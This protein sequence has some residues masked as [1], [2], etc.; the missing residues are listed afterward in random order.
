MVILSGFDFHE[1]S[2]CESQST[3]CDI[4]N[5]AESHIILRLLLHGCQGT[6]RTLLAVI[7]F[8][9]VAMEVLCLMEHWEQHR[10][11]P[12]CKNWSVIR[13][14]FSSQA[15]FTVCVESGGVAKISR[16]GSYEHPKAQDN[17]RSRI[18]WWSKTRGRAYLD[19]VFW[20]T[21][22]GVKLA[23]EERL[24]ALGQ[25]DIKLSPAALSL[26]S[27]FRNILGDRK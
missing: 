3:Q 14:H 16:F 13:D 8:L 24:Q 2:S 12:Q 15:N 17:V 6:L 7:I 19:W 5:S 20:R 18:L 9:G 25:T 22:A 21:K 11:F 26:R 4:V 1:N 23:R 27:G 10:V